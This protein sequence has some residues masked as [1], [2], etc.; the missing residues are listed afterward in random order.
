MS[1][2]GHLLELHLQMPAAAD[3][4]VGAER[5]LDLVLHEGECLALL[6]SGVRDVEPLVDALA[7]YRPASPGQLLLRGRDIGDLPA[8]R[9]QIGLVSAR[10]P[11]FDHLSVLANLTFPLAARKLGRTE[12]DHRIRQTLALLGLEGLAPRRAASLAAAERVRVALA[13]VLV[14]EPALIVLEH[15]TSG[16]T[17]TERRDLRQ[18]LRRLV[19]ARG[20]SLLFATTEREEALVMGDRIGLLEGSRLHQVGTASELLD[21]PAN[22]AV[23]VWFGEANRLTGSVA[24]IEDDVAH[25]R[26]SAGPSMDCAAAP[27]LEEG[28][29]CV[30]CVRPER[31]ATAFVSDEE[32]FG[33]ERLAG[34]LA[35][36]LHLGDHLRLRFRLAGGGEI[37]AR[38]PA[39]QP[40]GSLHADRSALLAWQAVHAT[41]FPQ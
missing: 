16:L 26:L 36:I 32:S 35:E 11:L 14:C 2:P 39:A 20:L 12:S 5:P 33:E 23:A 6:A 30:V 18:I 1:A 41:A 21:R 40:L 24:W 27:G 13:R 9:R 17:L 31:I 8:G 28:G 38:R 4:A 7:G 19:R 3:G 22:E 29:L 25:V 15:P 34:T 37:L 10:D